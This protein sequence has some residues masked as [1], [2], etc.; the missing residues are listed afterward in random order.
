MGKLERK[1]NKNIPKTSHFNY[2]D[3]FALNRKNKT[4]SVISLRFLTQ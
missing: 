3:N 4:I 1:K 2:K